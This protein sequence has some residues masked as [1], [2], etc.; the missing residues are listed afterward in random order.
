MRREVFVAE[1]RDEALRLCGPALETK[2][3]AYV[4]WGQDKPMPEGD[5]LDMA[6][7]D[8]LKERFLIGSPDE[9]AEAILAI[10]RPHRRQSPHHQHPLAR[11]G[12]R[13]RHGCDA[14]LRGRGHAAGTERPLTFPALRLQSRTTWLSCGA[15]SGR[16]TTAIPN[17]NEKECDTTDDHTG[18]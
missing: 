5:G 18:D 14:T 15:L 3:K 2:Y 11:H 9:V 17:S 12:D 10:V 8:L 7:D 1:S 13:R 4:Q 6:L 16:S